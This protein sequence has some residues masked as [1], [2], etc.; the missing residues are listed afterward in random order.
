MVHLLHTDAH[1]NL[2]LFPKISATLEMTTRYIRSPRPF[3]AKR[4]QLLGFLLSAILMALSGASFA[5]KNEAKPLDSKIFRQNFITASCYN[6]DGFYEEALP[7]WK[8]LLKSAPENANLNFQLGVCYL[9]LPEFRPMA[10]DYLKKAIQS[11]DGGYFYHHK[12]QNAPVDA[13]FHLGRYYHTEERLDEAIEYYTQ[14]LTTAFRWHHLRLEAKHQIEACQVAM[15]KIQDPDEVYFSN[16]DGQLNTAFP[17]YCPV[18][19]NSGDTMYFTSR[20][21]RKN[22]ENFLNK[23]PNDGMFFEN[24][25]KV[26]RQSNGKWSDAELL[27]FCTIYEHESISALSQ[28]G[29]TMFISR[30]QGRVANLYKCMKRNNKWSSPKEMDPGLNSRW[31]NETHLSLSADGQTVY[32]VSDRWGGLGGKDIYQSH[33]KPDGSW[34]SPQ[35]LGPS[36]NTPFDEESPF[37]D[38]ITDRLYF[39]SQGHST[40]GGFDVFFSERQ[41]SGEWQPATSLGYP[42]NSTDDDVSYTISPDQVHAWYSTTQ[43]YGHQHRRKELVSVTWSK[44]VARPKNSLLA[45]LSQELFQEQVTDYYQQYNALQNAQK[46]M[47]SFRD[48]IAEVSPESPLSENAKSQLEAM[49][50]TLSGLRAEL[51]G[52]DQTEEAQV[53]IQK[54]TETLEVLREEL[55][56]LVYE[57][58][59]DWVDRIEGVRE[60]D[61][62]VEREVPH[63]ELVEVQVE[64]EVIVREVVEV[65]IEKIIETLKLIELE[66][67]VLVGLIRPEDVPFVDKVVTE[68]TTRQPFEMV[69]FHQHFAYNQQVIDTADKA[70]RK[71]IDDLV[72][73]MNALEEEDYLTVAIES[74][75]SKVPTTRFSSNQ[76]IAELRA[77]K[78]FETV[79]IC[80]RRRG[81]TTDRIQLGYQ[82]AWVKGPDYQSRKHFDARVFEKYQYVKIALL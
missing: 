32:F 47:E 33:R 45:Q 52:G 53:K 81:V 51:A 80:L 73:E 62:P 11:T 13:I 6:E 25:Y 55:I 8:H 50:Q 42:V 9:N 61:R 4:A 67:E 56:G 64:K 28:D 43:P 18:F 74:S 72:L 37:L 24:I 35:N 69:F 40:I 30:Y 41:A 54:V 27:N 48:A 71:F 12:E 68:V 78:A 29:K 59:L 3:Q 15:K 5:S 63:R 1:K 39:S 75:A 14:F 65:E 76:E 36:V 10:E 2:N 79:K 66:T 60:I 22:R 38:P 16:L 77:R 19:T 31:S 34:S 49:P 21:P 26:I 44:P 23:D 7:I 58:Q 46:Q 82:K 17:E 20:R 70:F 57:D